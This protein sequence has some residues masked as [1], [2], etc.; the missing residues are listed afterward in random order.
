MIRQNT[1]FE[2]VRKLF[3]GLRQYICRDCE[4][5]FRAPDRRRVPREDSLRAGA[6]S[7]HMA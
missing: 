6:G 4:T 1:G 3:T 7:K 5:K 2:R